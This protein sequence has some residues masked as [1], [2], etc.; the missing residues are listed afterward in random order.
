MPINKTYVFSIIIM[1]CMPSRK[2]HESDL[3]N[4]FNHSLI[5]QRVFANKYCVRK[6][7]I[8]F[9]NKLMIN[10]FSR[11]LYSMWFF[12]FLHGCLL[13]FRGY[14]VDGQHERA[15]KEW[16]KWICYKKYSLNAPFPRL[17]SLFPSF[18]PWS[19]VMNN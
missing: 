15:P 10:F 5:A 17:L 3:V 1:K 6:Q 14:V 16:I 12:F 2:D 4:W 11:F 9:L 18:M 7:T 13:F 19:D 8:F